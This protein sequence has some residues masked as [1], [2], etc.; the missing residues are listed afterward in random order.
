MTRGS[1]LLIKSSLK[2][3]GVWNYHNSITLLVSPVLH[4]RFLLLL[5]YIVKNYQLI[6]LSAYKLFLNNKVLD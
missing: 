4:G 2:S 6:Y 1:L 3:A 5:G